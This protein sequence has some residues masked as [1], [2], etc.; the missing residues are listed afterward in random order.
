GPNP[1]SI[2]RNSVVVGC[3]AYVLV[4][5]MPVIDMSPTASATA[6]ALGSMTAI[7]ASLVA[8]AQVDI[9][10]AMSHGTSAYLGLVFVAVGFQQHD[11][12]LL[13]LFTHGIAKASVFISFGSVILTTNNQDIREMGGLARSMPATTFAYVAGAWGLTGV[14]PLGTFWVMYR[15]ICEPGL[16][17][18][19]IG[20]A[21]I[22]NAL[23]ALSLV[24]VY[25]LVFAGDRKLKTRRAPEMPWPMAVPMVAMGI[26]NLLVPLMMEKWQLTLSSSIISST[27]ETL[28]ILYLGLMVAA[29]LIGAATGARLYLDRDTTEPVVLPWKQVQ[30]LFAYDFYIDHIYRITIAATIGAFSR[31]IAWIDRFII[32]GAVNVVGLVTLMGGEGLKYSTNGRSQAYV[33]VLLV[34]ISTLVALASL[35]T[36]LGLR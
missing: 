5:M 33:L 32:D 18:W 1:A 2:M 24:R 12:A 13:L 31:L 30:D 22:V 21:L 11:L 14:L 10:R 3:G 15:W 16:P 17:T 28:F 29:G 35:S 34:S 6:I 7:G 8:I 9:K 36:L 27:S 26:L 23:S 25:G 20:L 4:K 19:T